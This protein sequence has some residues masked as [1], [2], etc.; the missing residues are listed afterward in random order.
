M[1]V[2]DAAKVLGVPRASAYR[3]VA[4]RRA[5]GQ[6]ALVPKTADRSKTRK[7]TADQEH[8]LA[9]VITDT[10]PRDHGYGSALWTR[11]IIA[12]WVAARWGV[13]YTPRGIGNVLHR[14]RLSAQRPVVRAGEADPAR[15][16]A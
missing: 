5:G 7:L 4:L 8:E 14:L 11:A 2:E 3:W 13:T 12:D 9:A 10:D 6:A 15:Q 1:H 16:R